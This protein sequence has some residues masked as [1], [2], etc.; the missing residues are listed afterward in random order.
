M[1]WGIVN[2]FILGGWFGYILLIPAISMII[3][4]MDHFPNYYYK[5]LEPD[6][7]ERLN[8]KIEDIED[9]INNM[10]RTIHQL[11]NT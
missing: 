7:Y 8:S 3:N 1:E 5:T 6:G 10:K 11:G 2:I 4:M 9:E